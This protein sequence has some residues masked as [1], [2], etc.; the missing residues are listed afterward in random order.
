MSPWVYISDGKGQVDNSATEIH[1]NIQG[2]IWIKL[3]QFLWLKVLGH[4]RDIFLKEKWKGETAETMWGGFSDEFLRLCPVIGFYYLMI[5]FYKSTIKLFNFGC[6]FWFQKHF[7]IHHST[8]ISWQPCEKIQARVTIPIL[9]TKL[10]KNP[11]A[12]ME[13]WPNPGLLIPSQSYL[14]FFNDSQHSLARCQSMAKLSFK[15]E[16]ETPKL[17]LQKLNWLYFKR[18]FSFLHY[19]CLNICIKRYCHLL[20]DKSSFFHVYNRQNWKLTTN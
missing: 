8:W 15:R 20:S 10:R 2:G 18:C 14:K 13:W 1:M 12:S 9:Q 7:C 16:K 19:N 11:I 6:A 5:I 17:P 3:V 4:R